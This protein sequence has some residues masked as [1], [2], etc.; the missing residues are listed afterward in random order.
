MKD[1]S[2][3]WLDRISYNRPGRLNCVLYT[4]LRR[5]ATDFSGISF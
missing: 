1:F 2:P 5:S 4:S 3:G